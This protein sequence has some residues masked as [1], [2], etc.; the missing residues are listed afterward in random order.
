M[1]EDPSDEDDWRAVPDEE[2]GQYFWNIRTGETRWDMPT[3]TQSRSRTESGG[4]GGGESSNGWSRAFAEDG[5]EYWYHAET[6]ETRWDAPGGAADAEDGYEWQELY[7]PTSGK[8]YYVHT[9]THETR[10][11]RPEPTC[12]TIASADAEP[13][14]SGGASSAG[15]GPKP[16][17]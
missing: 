7:D 1:P 15:R 11:D 2:G 3:P 14:A 10:W 4:S 8:P 13:S 5:T 9:G 12:V 6:G 16:I 17:L